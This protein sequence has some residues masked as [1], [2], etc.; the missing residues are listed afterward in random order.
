MSLPSVLTLIWYLMHWYWPPWYNT[1]TLAC[2]F[3]SLLFVQD[4]SA[5]KER[6]PGEIHWAPCE[7]IMKH[8][9]SQ[10]M[11]W[12]WLQMAQGPKRE[13]RNL[14]GLEQKMLKLSR[15]VPLSKPWRKWRQRP[16]YR[17]VKVL[18]DTRSDGKED[19]AELGRDGPKIVSLGQSAHPISGSVWRP[20]WPRWP[21]GYLQSLCEE[22][23]II[24]FIIRYRG[25]EKLEGHHYGEVGHGSCLGFP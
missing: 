21:L 14:W 17:R 2:C 7:K 5:K 24:T 3:W 25:A 12:T 4:F 13:G 16:T 10:D 11:K 1:F 15:Q 8:G 19:G 22:P 18:E 23:H 9:T 20:L 6:L